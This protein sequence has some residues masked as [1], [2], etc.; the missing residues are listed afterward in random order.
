MRNVA[1]EL[2]TQIAI[3]VFTI[4]RSV[5]VPL[6]SIWNHRLQNGQFWKPTWTNITQYERVTQGFCG[7]VI[8]YFMVRKGFISVKSFA[9]GLLE[10]WIVASID[11]MNEIQSQS[12]GVMALQTSWNLERTC[13]CTSVGFASGFGTTKIVVIVLI[14]KKKKASKEICFLL[15][16][17]AARSAFTGKIS[18]VFSY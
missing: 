12:R 17:P 15:V 1:R 9:C 11:C 10:H 6:Y 3:E 14:K 13:P 7:F 4:F 16:K 18:M 2:S 8:R 5:A